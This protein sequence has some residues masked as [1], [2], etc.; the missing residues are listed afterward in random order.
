MPRRVRAP[1][2]EEGGGGIKNFI[3]RKIFS[4]RILPLFIFSGGDDPSFPPEATETTSE[5][6]TSWSLIKSFQYETN[7]ME[8]K[9]D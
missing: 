9:L 1:R 6:K 3:L 8:Q 4:N 2:H 5:I 7:L